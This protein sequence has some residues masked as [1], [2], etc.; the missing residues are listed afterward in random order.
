MEEKLKLGNMGI[1]SLFWADDL[2]LFAETKEGLDKLLKIL[3][4]YCKEN[5]LLI[6]TKRQNRMTDE[7]TVLPRWC[8]IGNG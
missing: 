8:Q 1:N 3:E 5:H 6:N 4:G 2:V 7:K